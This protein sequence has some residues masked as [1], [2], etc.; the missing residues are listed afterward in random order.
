MEKLPMTRKFL[1]VMLSVLAFSSVMPSKGAHAAT[2]STPQLLNDG[3]RIDVVDAKTGKIIID[4]RVFLLV[5]ATRVI[6]ASGRPG[7]IQALRRGSMVNY[8]ALW[9][10]N[11]AAIPRMVEIVILPP[12]QKPRRERD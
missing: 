4:D 9:D 2:A 11:A 3:G 5:P 12:G 6:D 10:R 1:L 8:S 7:S